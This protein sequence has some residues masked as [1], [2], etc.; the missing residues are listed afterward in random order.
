[1][2][3]KLFVRLSSGV[4]LFGGPAPAA[5]AVEAALGDELLELAAVVAAALLE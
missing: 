4:Q 3:G 5:A 1:M 2:F